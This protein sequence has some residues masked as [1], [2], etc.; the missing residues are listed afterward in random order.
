MLCTFFARRE[1]ELRSDAAASYA[2]CFPN[3]P[4]ISRPAQQPSQLHQSSALS[5]SGLSAAYVDPSEFFPT[6]VANAAKVASQMMDAQALQTDHRQKVLD[7]LAHATSRLIQQVGHEKQPGIVFNPDC[8]NAD[9]VILRFLP[10]GEQKIEST[11]TTPSSGT[12]SLFGPRSLGWISSSPWGKSAFLSM[13]RLHFLPV[14]LTVLHS[15]GLPI[16]RF[17]FVKALKGKLRKHLTRII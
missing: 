3:A 10:T 15:S 13:L 14:L 16:R 6:R 7:E 17:P 12:E 4:I 2:A 1:K 11:D 5:L 9:T 8:F